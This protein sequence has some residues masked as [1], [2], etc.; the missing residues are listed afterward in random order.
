MK[1]GSWLSIRALCLVPSPARRSREGG[2]T[3]PL[4]FRL[5]AAKR[6][7]RRYPMREEESS[8]R[9][10]P[11]MGMP[12]CMCRALLREREGVAAMAV[13]IQRRPA[14]RRCGTQY[15]LA[16]I[17]RVSSGQDPRREQRR[18]DIRIVCVG[19]QQEVDA[20]ERRVVVR[21]DP[22][23]LDA[24]VLERRDLEELPS[25]EMTPTAEPA[26]TFCTVTVRSLP[27]GC[28]DETS[29]GVVGDGVEVGEVDLHFVRR[30]LVLDGRSRGRSSRTRCSSSTPTERSV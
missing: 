30:A 12:A 19:D 16:H 28:E 27:G 29:V 7:A 13:T 17:R 18:R 25:A 8:G 5:T 6:A 4:S 1:S 24:A 23:E 3:L 15:L 11:V 2:R 20:A 21:V 22:F 26:M 9:R 14:D 10:T